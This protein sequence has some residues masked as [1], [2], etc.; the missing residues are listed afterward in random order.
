MKE[1]KN[2][3]DGKESENGENKN[4][5]PDNKEEEDG[6]EKK[7][8]K[9]KYY[10]KKIKAIPVKISTKFTDILKKKPSKKEKSHSNETPLLSPVLHNTDIEMEPISDIDAPDLTVY[11]EHHERGEEQ[12]TKDLNVQDQN[13]TYCDTS[14]AICNEVQ[15]SSLAQTLVTLVQAMRKEPRFA[16]LYQ[17]QLQYVIRLAIK[18]D[19][20][21]NDLHCLL[22]WT[23]TLY[24][25]FLKEYINQAQLG[26]LLST[27][28]ACRLKD[29]YIQKQKEELNITWHKALESEEKC[30]EENPDNLSEI[31][32]NILQMFN[33]VFKAA[34]IISDDFLNII[35]PMVESEFLQFLNRYKSSIQ[36]YSKKNRTKSH[37]REIIMNNMNYCSHF[38]DFVER[39]FASADK[40]QKMNLVLQEIEEKGFNILLQDL[41]KHID[42]NLGM[43]SRVKGL[44]SQEIMQENISRATVLLSSL[45]TLSDKCRQVIAAKIHM[46]LVTKYLTEIK[47]I[48][49]CNTAEQKALASQMD[50]TEQLLSQFSTDHVNDDQQS[51]ATWANKVIGKI[52]NII[53]FESLETIKQEVG[54]LAEE[55]PDIRRRHVKSFLCIKINLTNFERM[56]AVTMFDAIK[57]EDP[58]GRRLFIFIPCRPCHC[59]IL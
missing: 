36:T 39:D 58:P 43:L 30:W 35:M 46:H 59:L 18:G 9:K 50:N 12:E 4:N 47:D 24:P 15:G 22:S 1:S 57:Q 37:F 52:A 49:K 19:L 53:R 21:I 16:K 5:S 41:F 33:G 8:E 25:N 45:P 40:K 42:C 28:E 31:S 27:D 20:E 7:K 48:R 14:P 29:K 44:N 10:L 2:E 38:R 6:K 54:V 55:Y 51:D 17:Q 32:H 11:E 34:K 13:L 3:S 26:E 56:S 23:K